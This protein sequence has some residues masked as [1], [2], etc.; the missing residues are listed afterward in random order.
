MSSIPKGPQ[1]Q[2]KDLQKKNICVYSVKY[3]ITEALPAISS[4]M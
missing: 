1:A 3:S 4:V 2:D